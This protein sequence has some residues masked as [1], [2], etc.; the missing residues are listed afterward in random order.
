M[1]C[2]KVY[3]V[4]CGNGDCGVLIGSVMKDEVFGFVKNF[5]EIWIVWIDLKFGY[6]LWVVKVVWNKIGLLVFVYIVQIDKDDVW[7]FYQCYSCFCVD[8]FYLC[9]CFSDQICGC[10]F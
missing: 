8:F 1:S 2:F 5:F 7:I 4:Q 3:V 9:V 6:V 10:F